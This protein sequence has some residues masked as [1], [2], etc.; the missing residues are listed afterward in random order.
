MDPMNQIFKDYLDE[1]VIIFVDDILIYSK[2]EDHHAKHLKIIVM[3]TLKDQKL[4]TKFKKYE[5]WL[6]SVVFFGHIINSNDI[7]IDP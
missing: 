4:Y 5:F 6:D 3:Q 2:D 7:S 1:F